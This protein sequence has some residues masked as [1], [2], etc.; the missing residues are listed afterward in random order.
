MCTVGRMSTWDS[1]PSAGSGDELPEPRPPAPGGHPD[2]P[3]DV[4]AFGLPRP[5]PPEAPSD[6]PSVLPPYAGSE[7]P[8]PPPPSGRSRA[9]LWVVAALVAVL[10]VG[11]VGLSVV[12]ADRSEPPPVTRLPTRSATP[13]PT[14]PSRTPPSD[15]TP[16]AAPTA[17][18]PTA[19]LPTPTRPT[20]GRPGATAT[21]P[22]VAP[23]V[24][25]WQAVEGREFVAF[26]V[27]PDWNV[28][29]PTALTGFE[30]SGGRPQIVIVHNTATYRKGACDGAPSTYRAKAGFVSVKGQTAGT[31]ATAISAQWAKVAG[32]HE[33]GSDSPVGPTQV[34]TVQIAAG[35]IA[36]TVAT[37]VLTVTEPG[38][39]PAPAMSFTAVSFSVKGQVVVFILYAD[40][41]VA[42]ALPDDVAA[43]VISSLRPI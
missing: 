32:V 11:A 20:P 1:G 17:A 13:A 35:T 28:E 3:N 26:D 31:A 40:Q 41:G 34:S 21:P 10:L 12:Y 25:G 8:T 37:T 39:C 27:P 6:R 5:R 15:P 42:D 2:A 18:P 38:D 43:Q 30:A 4:D 33:D 7:A 24:P 19:T 29:S 22:Q 23:V 9:P 16:T 36:A 14:D